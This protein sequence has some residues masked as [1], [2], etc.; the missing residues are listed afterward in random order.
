ME[1]SLTVPHL[2]T[3]AAT[4]M[5]LP[6]QVPQADLQGFQHAS[7][8][9]LSPLFQLLSN[10]LFTPAFRSTHSLPLKLKI[11]TNSLPAS[12]VIPT[13]FLPRSNHNLW[14]VFFH[15][16]LTHQLILAKLLS[17]YGRTLEGASFSSRLINEMDIFCFTLS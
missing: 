8:L 10:E 14:S 7:S 13:L 12:N 11:Q 16:S 17:P 6:H 5:T 15:V 9:S 3:P 4:L 1:P 2:Y